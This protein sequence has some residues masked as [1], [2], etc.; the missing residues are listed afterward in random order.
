MLNIYRLT[1]D[2]YILSSYYTF[3]SRIYSLN[4]H[5]T[6]TIPHYFMI[7]L[8]L[9]CHKNLSTIY[10]FLFSVLG[11]SSNTIETRRLRMKPAYVRELTLNQRKLMVRLRQNNYHW[12]TDLQQGFTRPHGQHLRTILSL[13]WSGLKEKIKK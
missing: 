10:P 4:E 7:L 2:V 12:R 5:I 1:F 9:F 6:F 13:P 3:Q 8:N 11:R